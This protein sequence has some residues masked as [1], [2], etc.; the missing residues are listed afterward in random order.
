MAKNK[1]LRWGII[2]TAQI[3]REKMIPALQASIHN[4]VYAIASRSQAQADAFAKQAGIAHAYSDYEQL[5]NDPNID[6]IYNPLPNH[7]HVPWTIKAMEA[8]KHVLCEKPIGLDVSE[9]EKLIAATQKYPKLKVMEAFMYRFHP[10]WALAKQL[11]AE[12]KIGKVTTIDAVF[13]FH[14]VDAN[15]VRNQP[16]IGGGGLMDVGCYCISAARYL[17]DKEPLQVTGKLSMDGNFEIDKHANALLDFGDLQASI[18]CSMQS[19]PAQRVYIMGEKGS[20]TIEFPFYQ[21][22]D[23][24][25][26]LIIKHDQSPEVHQV[27]ACNHY[28][29]QADAL[30]IAINN[31]ADTPTPLTDALANMK[32]IDAIFKSHKNNSWV[33]INF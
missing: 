8:G 14:N 31:N 15:N 2:S 27:A 21:P 28:Q 19:E 18:F 26:R 6:V 17:L 10:Q 13:T 33:S 22:D 29:K 12:G 16:G 24:D 3:G 11:I 9:V 1:K 32:V 30:A 7:L 23:C 20:L 25:A 5:L 4:E